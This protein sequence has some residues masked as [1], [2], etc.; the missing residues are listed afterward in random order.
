MEGKGREGRMGRREMTS[1]VA[2]SEM[3][4]EWVNIHLS[5]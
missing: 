5:I 4:Y 1:L 2:C 3:V